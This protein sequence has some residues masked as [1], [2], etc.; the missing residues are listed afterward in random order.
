MV[1]RVDLFAFIRFTSPDRRRTRYCL[2]AQERTLQPLGGALVM[3]ESKRADFMRM[4]PTESRMFDTRPNRFFMNTEQLPDLYALLLDPRWSVREAEQAMYTSSLCTTGVIEQQRLQYAHSL[5]Y[6]GAASEGDFIPRRGKSPKIRLASIV[7]LRITD[8]NV[9]N[10][11]YRG[12]E[13]S[14][15]FTYVSGGEIN[16]KRTLSG[17][18]IDPICR[19]LLSPKRS[20]P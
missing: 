8:N 17:I 15:D 16:H 4:F 13:E 11:I 7:E 5:S 3:D 10:A 1:V 6:V 12:I 2:S 18:P 19:F 20:L 9:R 14:P